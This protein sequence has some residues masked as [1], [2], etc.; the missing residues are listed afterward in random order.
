[1]NY[2]APKIIMLIFLTFEPHMLPTQTN[3]LFLIFQFKLNSAHTLHSVEDIF[4]TRLFLKTTLISKK[5]KSKFFVFSKMKS[6]HFAVVLILLMATKSLHGNRILQ[7][8]HDSSEELP[9][10]LEQP[11]GVKEKS[12]EKP[13]D[14]VLTVE[15]LEKLLAD[16]EEIRDMYADLIKMIFDS[17]LNGA[18]ETTLTMSHTKKAAGDWVRAA[19]NSTILKK[20]LQ[21]HN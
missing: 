21:N 8:Q 9:Q 19:I 3:Y 4:S 12:T 7:K 17:K 11:L 16:A 18:A 2:L 6:F 10:K 20:R 5:N 15:R 1:M 14:A 13:T